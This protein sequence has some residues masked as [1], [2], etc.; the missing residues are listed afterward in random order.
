LQFTV[1]HCPRGQPFRL[2]LVDGL[3]WFGLAEGFTHY[4]GRWLLVWKGMENPNKCMLA[5][6]IKATTCLI[7][8]R[9]LELNERCFLSSDTLVVMDSHWRSTSRDSWRSTITTYQARRQH[10]ATVYVN[11]YVCKKLSD[12]RSLAESSM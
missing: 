1:R 9:C 6:Y 12:G 8:Q 5:P 2:V 10:S 7:R 11:L 3:F 4:L